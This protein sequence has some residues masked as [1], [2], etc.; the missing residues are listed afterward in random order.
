[1]ETTKFIVMVACKNLQQTGQGQNVV[2]IV[3]SCCSELL[4][5]LLLA[6]CGKGVL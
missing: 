2:H 4:L 6:W 3:F 5:H 1:M